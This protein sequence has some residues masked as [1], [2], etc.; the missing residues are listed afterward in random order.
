MALRISTWNINSVRLRQNLILRFLREKKPDILCLQETKCPND[1]FPCKVFIDAGYEHIFFEGMKSY[2]GVAIISRLPLTSVS[3]IE[4]AGRK[5]CRHIS[6]ITDDGLELHN[7]YVP[8]GGDEP[9]PQKKM[10]S[11]DTNYY[12]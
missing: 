11:L 5:D 9:D 6:A 12:F 8:A 1:Q 3:S 4:W 7:F 10:K 2:N